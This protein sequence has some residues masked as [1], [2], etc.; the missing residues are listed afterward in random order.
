MGRPRGVVV[1][2]SALHLVARVCGFRSLAQTNTTHQSFCGG[3]PHIKWRTTGTHVSSG[4]IF[5]KQKIKKRGLATD[6][7]SGL[8]FLRKIERNLWGWPHGLVVKFGALCFGSPGLRVQMHSAD[9]H[10]SS[11]MLWQWPTYKLEEDWQQMLALGKSS[12][13]KKKSFFN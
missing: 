11:A 6:L 7:S 4:L 1:K 3:N 13:G 8:I 9:P 5:L 12:S 10:H 2:F